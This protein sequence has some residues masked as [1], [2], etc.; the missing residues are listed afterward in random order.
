[1][2]TRAQLGSR[3]RFSEVTHA[4]AHVG[5]ADPHVLL[6]AEIDVRV[7]LG[8]RGRVRALGSGHGGVDVLPDGH[9]DLLEL[10]LLHA[11]LLREPRL[12]LVDRVALLADTAHLRAVAVG[13]ARVRHGVAVVAV[14]VELEHEGPRALAAVRGGVL[15]RLADHEHIL[16]VAPDSRDVLAAGVVV[17]VRRGP[18]LGGAHAVLV[19]LADKDDG[20]LPEGGHVHALEELALVGR[21][22]AVEGDRHAAVP[23][24]LVGKGQA[25]AQGLLGADD[26]VAAV[27]VV[28]G[29]VHVHGPPLPLGTARV[30]AHEL[31]DDTLHGAAARNLVAVVAVGGD[32][33]VLP[34]DGGL[35]ANAHG[36]LAVVQMAE[37]AH[38]LG[39]V[40]LVGGELHAAHRV[41]GLP[42]LHHLFL[43]RVHAGDAR[44]VTLV[45]LEGL[46]EVHVEGAGGQV[47]AP[48][49]RERSRA[50]GDR[51]LQH[52]PRLGRP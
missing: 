2:A 42:V 52:R 1:M 10:R 11:R 20:Q 40:Q 5:P 23:P 32:H 48:G 7:Q 6:L 21:T 49:G 24:V 27:E 13:D 44:A 45:G 50:R 12:G 19:V 28:L 26:A 8:D 34:R 38:L 25:H 31:R 51:A 36:L 14:R 46:L 29:L 35:H 4:H 47:A 16:A 33:R 22:V 30:L 39:L 3:A 43:G 18:G 15:D 9:L 37:A 17:R 41:H